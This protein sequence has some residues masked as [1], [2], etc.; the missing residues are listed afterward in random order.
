MAHSACGQDES[1]SALWFATRAGTMELSR[2]LG[3]TRRVLH[4]N[5]P[6]KPYNKSFID[7]AC[8]VQIAGYCP[9][10]L[11]VYGRRQVSVHKHAKKKRTANIQPSW[12]HTWSITHT[13]YMFYWFSMFYMLHQFC[14]HT[15]FPVFLFCHFSVQC[16]AAIFGCHLTFPPAC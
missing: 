11:R 7:Q 9:R 4:E 13:C 15:C 12:P 3:T 5:S 14:N 8:S 6:R 1:H 16:W 2:P 10:F